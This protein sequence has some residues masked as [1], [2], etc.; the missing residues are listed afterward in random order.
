MSILLPTPL[1]PLLLNSTQ[2]NSTPTQ[3]NSYFTQLL[4]YSPS[5]NRRS[6]GGKGCRE[7]HYRLGDH[8]AFIPLATDRSIAIHWYHAFAAASSMATSFHSS[9]VRVDGLLD[10]I[11]SW[12]PVPVRS[13]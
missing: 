4:L 8:R 12:T 1:L 9:V 10:K 6:C 5:T 13:T 11:G 7:C 2:L 3:P